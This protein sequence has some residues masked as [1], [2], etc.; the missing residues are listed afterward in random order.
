MSEN[1]P[2]PIEEM[3]EAIENA[4]YDV[5]EKHI[6][7][8]QLPKGLEYVLRVE[9]EDFMSESPRATAEETAERAGVHAQTVFRAHRDARYIAVKDRI[10][11]IYFQGKADR[12]YA[13]TLKAADAGKVGA[14]KLGLEMTGKHVDRSESKSVNISADV[15]IDGAFNLDAA[16]DRFLIMVGNR[17]WSLEMLADRW[18]QLKT[19]QAF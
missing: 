10:Q 3:E 7:I 19:E 12:F 6:T 18:R 11:D 2:V 5:I 14:I 13:A 8:A 4:D 17:G 9:M 1:V 15:G 16:I